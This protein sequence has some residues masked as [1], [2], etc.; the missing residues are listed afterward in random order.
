MNQGNLQ[1]LQGE[2]GDNGGSDPQRAKGYNRRHIGE[3][4]EMCEDP[5][6]RE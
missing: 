6:Q 1:F 3:E 5:G 4:M 2:A